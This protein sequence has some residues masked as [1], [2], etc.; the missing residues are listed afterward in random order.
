MVFF[1]REI[2]EVEIGMVTKTMNNLLLCNLDSLPT[3]VLFHKYMF[4]GI[5]L[6]SIETYTKCIN[7]HVPL[8]DMSR[9]GR[10]LREVCPRRY[11]EDREKTEV[12]ARIL[13][14]MCWY[15]IITI[16]QFQEDLKNALYHVKS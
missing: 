5:G 13:Q 3:Q 1:L 15:Q 14:G 9:C 12:C 4:L 6:T 16:M 2:S 7:Y 10:Y 11:M 8:H